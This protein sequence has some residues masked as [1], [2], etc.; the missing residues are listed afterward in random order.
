MAR[1]RVQLI[2]CQDSSLQQNG[3]CVRLC[4]GRTNEHG[5]TFFLLDL[6]LTPRTPPIP[7]HASSTD[8]SLVKAR[9]SCNTNTNMI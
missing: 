2:E 5:V 6:Q 9:S 4:N 3:A 8:D 1:I 7:Q